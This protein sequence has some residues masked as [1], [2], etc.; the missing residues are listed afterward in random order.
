VIRGIERV[1][2]V[3]PK[4]I[5]GTS[6]SKASP[7]TVISALTHLPHPTT[8]NLLAMAALG[9]QTG[10]YTKEQIVDTLTTA[11]TTFLGAVV[12]SQ[13]ALSND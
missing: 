11:Y 10:L 7:E 12:E 3:N 6:F 13:N 1:L 5:Y 4:G 2:S 8:T 9:Y